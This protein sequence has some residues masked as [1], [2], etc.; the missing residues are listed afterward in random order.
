M[1]STLAAA[2][3]GIISSLDYKLPAVSSYVESRNEVTFFP[4]GGNHF[5]S[6]GVRTLT[7][8]MSGSGFADL[9]SM[10]M[11]AMPSN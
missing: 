2:E 8:A 7:F 1:E 11:E 10:T 9:S 5:S 4:Q 6:T 3:E